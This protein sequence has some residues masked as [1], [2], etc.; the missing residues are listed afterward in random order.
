MIEENQKNNTISII[1]NINTF[2]S[3]KLFKIEMIRIF[4]VGKKNI[5]IFHLY[6]YIYISF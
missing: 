6:I 5:Y 1:K 2:S 4:F 3:R